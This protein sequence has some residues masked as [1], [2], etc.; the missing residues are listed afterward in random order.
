MSINLN[1]NFEI[2]SSRLLSF[3]LTL[4]TRLN[5]GENA[6]SW[7]VI[8]VCVRD[9]FHVRFD[10]PLLDSGG[11]TSVPAAVVVDHCPIVCFACESMAFGSV[12]EFV[13]AVFNAYHN[14]TMSEMDR[15]VG[16]VSV[17]TGFY[18]LPHLPTCT[19]A[20]INVDDLI[21]YVNLIKLRRFFSFGYSNNSAV[22]QQQGAY[23]CK[24]CLSKNTD[25]ACVP[26][27]HV[28]AC[29]DCMLQNLR[30]AENGSPVG[31]F[32]CRTIVSGIQQ[33]YYA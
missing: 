11:E 22:V 8:R 20:S 30:T 13:H 16:F 18:R 33:L 31:C 2:S 1:Q 15:R 12:K 14:N 3:L 7:N 19:R 10:R 6:F 4:Y 25:V 28:Y 9:G 27:G 24:I 29:F 5:V 17:D 32:V 26:C 23:L 21:S